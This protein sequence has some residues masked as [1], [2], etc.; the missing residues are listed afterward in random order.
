MLLSDYLDKGAS[1]DPSAPCISVAGRARSYREVQRLSWLVARALARSGVRPGEKAAILAHNDPVAFSCVFGISRAGAIWCP[2]DP[3][4]EPERTVK[5]L[6]HID[7]SCLIFSSAFAPL[8]RRIAGELPKLRLLVCVDSDPAVAPDPPTAI[9]L[10]QWLADLPD[11]PFAV[12]PVSDVAA[13]MGTETDVCDAKGV[14]LTCH[15]YETMSAATLSTY[16]FGDR[17]VYLP[18]LPVT[19]GL[20]M[21]TFPVLAL[22][23]EIT[24]LPEF[25]VT[26]FLSTIEQRQ[27]THAF[28]P[29][30]VLNI[31]LS[32][33]GLSGARLSSLRCVWYDSGVGIPTT[34]LAD[35][36]ARIGPVLAQLY[37]QPEVM[38]ISGLEPRDHFRPD[39]TLAMERLASAGRP[40]EL[41]TVGIMDQQGRLLA[42][43]EPGEIVTRGPLVMAGYYADPAGS[44]AAKRYGWYHTGETGYLDAD[45][46]LYIVQRARDLIAIGRFNAYSAEVEQ[47]LLR[48]PAVRTCA[49]MAAPDVAWGDRVTAVIQTRPGSR[50][51]DG[52]LRAF[53]QERL[54]N[55]AP[56][57]VEVWSGTREPRLTSVLR[58]QPNSR[59]SK[60]AGLRRR[61]PPRRP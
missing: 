38:V 49:V 46:Y 20:A 40:T 45:N 53:L 35:A 3:H 13:I 59:P 17:P 6:D 55:R 7:C 24:L 9:P 54:G 47:A 12:Q 51:A 23:G 15:N 57:R 14:V 1:L 21:F 50:L 8:V 11:T 31:L 37:M 61:T 34:K 44:A 33:P 48:H 42:A 18:I 39:G 60:T 29:S 32:H 43:G 56:S 25:E 30:S 4:N 58:Y 2:V 27:V 36:I 22:G 41:T 10:R 19:R 28:L 26:D 52:E 16:P 5:V